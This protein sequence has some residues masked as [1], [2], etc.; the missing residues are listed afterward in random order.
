MNP[1]GSLSEGGAILAVEASIAVMHT[2]FMGSSAQR[3][4][5]VRSIESLLHLDTRLFIDCPVCS[6]IFLERS[7]LSQVG[8]SVEWGSALEGGFLF[9]AD[10]TVELDSEN[11]IALPH[12]ATSG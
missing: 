4:G 5:C 6:A 7:T 11:L 8:G 9:A 12:F 10:S 2:Q 1:F 3:G